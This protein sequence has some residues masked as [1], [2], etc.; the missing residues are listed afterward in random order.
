MK[1]RESNVNFFNGNEIKFRYNLEFTIL[2]GI[3][4]KGIFAKN[5]LGTVS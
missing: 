3:G 1:M 4:P 2:I 5:N